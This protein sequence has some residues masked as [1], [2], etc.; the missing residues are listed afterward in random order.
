MVLKKDRKLTRQ[1]VKNMLTF[2]HFRFRERLIMKSKITKD[3][4]V[5]TLSE[6]YT[7]KTCGACGFINN[8]LGSK[9]VLKCCSCHVEIDR[10]LNGARNIMIKYLTELKKHLESL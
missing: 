4:K 2:S 9:K 6:E 5:I 1:T 3:F 8:K 7:S 10:D